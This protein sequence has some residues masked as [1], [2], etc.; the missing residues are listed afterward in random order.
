MARAAKLSG[1]A[2]RSIAPKAK[3][4]A[5]ATRRFRGCAVERGPLGPPL[6]D[7]GRLF[8]ATG[9]AIAAT[10]DRG[11]ELL[12]VHLERGDDLVCV[13]LATE[14]DVALGLARVL[15]DILDCALGLLV[16]FLV[17][18]LAALVVAGLLEH[19]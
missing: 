11:E 17:R 10:L 4:G 15:D 1:R 5:R 6:A 12:E 13:V 18:D 19:A 7:F 2:P 14:A 3:T 8:L 9:Q 16:D